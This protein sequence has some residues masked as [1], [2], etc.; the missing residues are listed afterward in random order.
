[1][2]DRGRHISRFAGFTDA[3]DFVRRL[4]LGAIG[5]LL[6]TVAGVFAAMIGA[7]DA[8]AQPAG[9]THPQESIYQTRGIFLDPKEMDRWA[10]ASYWEQKVAEAF[11][12]IVDPRMQDDAE[13]RDAVLAT[14]W[15]VKRESVNAETKILTFIP[16]R[17]AKPRSKDL[18]YLISFIPR[19]N[20][21]E[22]DAVETRFI[23]EGPAAMP[24][25]APEPPGPGPRP[26]S[27][28]GYAGFPQNNIN[29]Y[30]AEHPGEMKGVLAWIAASAGP[31]FNQI[32]RTSVAQAGGIRSAYFH[33]AGTKIPSGTVAGLAIMF[34]GDAAPMTARPPEQRG[35]RDIADLQ[36]EKLQAEARAHDRIGDITGLDA[37]PAD[38]RF[39]AKVAVWQ[40]FA[41]GTRD[42][43][44]DAIVPIP[45]TDRRAL[46]TLR[47]GARNNVSIQHVGESRK[48]SM[49][50]DPGDVRRVNGFAAN[51]ATPSALVAWLKKRYPGVPPKGST[52]AELAESVT[53][54]IQRRGGTPA[55]FKENY[56][57]DVLTA[58]DAP[59]RLTRTFEYKTQALGNLQDFTPSEL[60]TLESTLERM[61]DSL[62]PRLRGLVMARQ[63]TAVE[64]IG[65]TATKV[66]VSD[67]REGGIAR[68][69][70]KDRLIVIFDAASMHSDALFTGG[71]GVNGKPEVAAQLLW[72][73]AHELGHVL[74]ATPGAKESF[75]GLVRSKGIKPVTWYAAS[76]PMDEFL[77][78]TFALY[79]GDPEWLKSNRPDLFRWFE[80]LSALASSA[81]MR[82]ADW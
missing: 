40:Y 57:I 33:V 75:E 9:R 18:A 79:V 55:W 12:L 82:R 45:K 26:P 3:T 68:L 77:P 2:P 30:W 13:E 20:P 28:F 39:P 32:L 7:V 71:S 14:V 58:A 34:L 72:T 63:K 78:E 37:L 27:S 24:V 22:K 46:V 38:E 8:T 19:A 6:V 48:G 49:L 70:G 16:K 69:H 43:E 11:K 73:F 56:G 81:V 64:L 4:L 42:G 29:R 1:M 25:A 61:S 74:A 59:G 54:E 41:A 15:Q 36:I 53:A 47:F 10:S 5:V 31:A 35:A 21:K 80:T 51:S 76:N 62:V 65:V 17:S 66:A 60:Q 50:G 44:V 23:A 67:W 52:V